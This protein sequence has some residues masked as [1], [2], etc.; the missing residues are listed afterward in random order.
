[1]VTKVPSSAH[2]CSKARLGSW[3]HEAGLGSVWN[4]TQRNRGRASQPWQLGRPG[5]GRRPPCSARGRSRFSLS[6][7]TLTVSSGSSRGSLA[8]SR[9]SL[10]SS[11]GSLSSVSFTDIYGL[12][13]Y[14]RPDAEGGQLLRFDLI[15]FDALGRDAPFAEA[16]GPSGF[17]KQRRSLDT[18]QSL[19]S[20]SSRSSLSS[21]SPPSSPLDTPF[22]PASRDSPL[23]PLGDGGVEGPGLGALD[24]LRAPASALGEEELPGP[25]SL[26]PHGLPGDAEGPRERQ[27]QAAAAAAA[28]AGTGPPGR[29]RRLC[30]W[31]DR[32]RGRPGSSRGRTAPALRASSWALELPP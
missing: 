13:Q 25:A 23:A 7:S 26:P 10:A 1:M 15:P 11:R 9:G 19:A 2:G 8:S 5:P 3:G 18:P 22:L 4:R 21:L 12:P 31:G 20:L 32:V 6:A 27:P 29:G 30:R 14:E 16:A 28:G 24:R 17:Q